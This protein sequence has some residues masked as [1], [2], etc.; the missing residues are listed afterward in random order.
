WGL[1]PA[2]I[3]AV[4]WMTYPFALW[5]T[6]QPNSELPFMVV[7]YAGLLLF[8]FGVVR[9]INTWPL[10]SICGF[11]LGIAMLIR[12]FAIG[13]G[14]V[15]A[16]VVWLVKCDV[17]KHSRLLMTMAILIGNTAAV[18]PWELWAYSQTGK[19]ILLGTVGVGGM[20]DGLTF[21]A[22][23]KNYRKES[24]YSPDVTVVMS[25]FRANLMG[26]ETLSGIATGVAKEAR[27]HPVG[28]TK[29]FLLKAARSWYGT[30]S[31]RNEGWIQLI[32]F[33]YLLAL[34]WSIRNVWRLDGMRRWFALSVLLLVLYFWVM[35]IVGTSLLRYTVPVAGLVFLLMAGTF[36]AARPGAKSSNA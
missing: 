23:R 6:K 4:L 16:L 7:F 10:Y 36:S 33:F 11:L 2:V 28:I 29:L 1:L 26:T 30:D 21:G 3:S 35:S 14:L 27:A 19:V 22:D 5:L 15:M 18:L 25:D 20:R 12:P 24:N 31:L 13:L 17:S 8:W 32:Q 9:R 34:L